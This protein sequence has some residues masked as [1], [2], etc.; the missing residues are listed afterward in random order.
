MTKQNFRLTIIEKDTGKNAGYIDT[1]AT[2]E[3]VKASAS[4]IADM[5][6]NKF[7]IIIGDC[8]VYE[9][10]DDRLDQIIELLKNRSKN[11]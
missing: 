11:E 2:L 10:L 3:E 5:L 4:G 6:G 7:V 8:P 1:S 9:S